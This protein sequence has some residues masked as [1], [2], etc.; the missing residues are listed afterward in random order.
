MH[1]PC[2]VARHLPLGAVTLA[3]ACGAGAYL[4]GKAF[5]QSEQTEVLIGTFNVGPAGNVG[6]VRKAGQ[7][8]TNGQNAVTPAAGPDKLVV[9]E[10]IKKDAAELFAAAQVERLRGRRQT[11]RRMLELLVADHPDSPLADKARKALS[12]IY[13]EDLRAEVGPLAPAQKERTQQGAAA[14][15]EARPDL[16]TPGSIDSPWQAEVKRGDQMETQFARDTGDRVFFAEVSA[17]L[18]GRARAVLQEQARWLLQRPEVVAVVEGHADE[19]GTADENNAISM[20]RAEAVRQRLIEEGV[21]AQRLTIAARG[22]TQRVSE[23]EMPECA[24]QNRRVVTIVQPAQDRQTLGIVPDYKSPQGDAAS[25][26]APDQGLNVAGH[27]RPAHD[28]PEP[29]AR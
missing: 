26:T 28:K 9:D 3:V 7:A 11:A 16:A 12:E 25:A 27:D 14:N 1:W 29:A 4:P 21:E 23:C 20:R 5:A 19:P 6:P 22:R 13:I 8:P 15:G 24:A 2:R 18:G 10:R 17:E